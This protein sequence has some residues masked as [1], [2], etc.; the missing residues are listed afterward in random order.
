MN[1]KTLTLLKT[2]DKPCGVV[3]GIKSITGLSII[4]N[5]GLMK[6]PTI[7]VDTSKFVLGAFSK[8]CSS[9][10]VYNG[11]EELLSFL[12]E[13]GRISK[14]KN[15]IFCEGDRYVLFIDKYKDEVAK[16]FCL[17]ASS[18][19]PISEIM[20]KSRM[21]RLAKTAELDVPSTFL[22]DEDSISEIKEN[23][24]YP[25][26][27]KP[28]F[29]QSWSKKK[30]EIAR[31]NQ[32][33]ERAISQE[34]FKNGYLVQE[35]IE[36]PETNLWH[37]VG[38]RGKNVKV[39]FTYYKVRQ[40]PKDF[41]DATFAISMRNK[42]IEELGNKFLNYI[43]HT[44]LFRI[45]FK[46]DIKDGKYKFIESDFRA[47]VPNELSVASGI[48]LVYLAYLDVLNT[49]VNYSVERKDGLIWV[50]IIDDFI[51][52]F[53][54]YS[55][56]NK[57]IFSDWIKTIFGADTYADFRFFDIWP[58]ILKVFYHLGFIRN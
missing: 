23:I 42:D 54:Y 56:T 58:F 48:N 16:H 3:L 51:T 32:E 13:V 53:K 39:E 33:L 46:K 55:K 47:C 20:N 1:K 29:S 8:F 28:L 4:R 49:T 22:S 57:L 9:A 6:I 38:Y 12:K 14:Y 43:G 18:I 11:E 52:C 31:N 10:E 5:L 41:G 15:V 45:E 27:I 26:F 2:L 44:G 19:I 50:S 17:T 24:S 34:R 36:G 21:I 40:K 35:I 25:S 30:G 37:Y 7:G